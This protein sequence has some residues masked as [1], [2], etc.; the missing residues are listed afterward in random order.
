MAQ[1]MNLTVIVAHAPPNDSSEQGR[2][3][4]WNLLRKAGQAVRQAARP[5]ALSLS[6]RTEEWG[7]PWPRPFWVNAS[8]VIPPWT[9]PNVKNPSIFILTLKAK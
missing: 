3:S 7:H 9:I 6:T 2:K 8:R 5:L 4:F 1:N